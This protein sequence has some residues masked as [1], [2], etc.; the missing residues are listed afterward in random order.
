MNKS[1]KNSRKQRES[2]G[3][4]KSAVLLVVGYH[5][6][7]N[8]LVYMRLRLPKAGHL[9]SRSCEQ[10]HLCLWHLNLLFAW[11]LSNRMD[12]PLGFGSSRFWSLTGWVS[13]GIFRPLWTSISSFA[14]EVVGHCCFDLHVFVISWSVYIRAVSALVSFAGELWANLSCGNPE[15]QIRNS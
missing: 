3:F 5:P 7:L 13:S 12:R 2:W 10:G 11:V 15:L 8:N 1:R 6:I 4:L 9:L 14:N